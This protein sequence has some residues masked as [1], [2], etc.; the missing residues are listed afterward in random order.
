MARFG[1]GIRPHINQIYERAKDHYDRTMQPAWIAQKYHDFTKS[2]ADSL[3]AAMY[4]LAPQSRR[5]LDVK[6][7]VPDPASP[8]LSE[9]VPVWERPARTVG[10]VIRETGA[11]RALEVQR[12][13]QMLKG[14]MGYWDRVNSE[15]LR[16]WGKNPIGIPPETP[17][18]DA[19]AFYRA[20]QSGKPQATPEM[21]KWADTWRTINKS[22]AEALES[23]GKVNVDNFDENYAP[24]LW[25]H[26][27]SHEAPM[28]GQ[29]VAKAP[30]KSST[31]FLK[32][33]TF[34]TLDEGLAH[35]WTPI[36]DNPIE[37]MLQRHDMIQRYVQGQRIFS[38]MKDN[39]IARMSPT[40]KK[41][42]QDGSKSK[43][44]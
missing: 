44:Q 29:A 34:T 8:H 21:Q 9:Y 12:A 23:T 22:D 30:L 16:K 13:H 33:K 25:K 43:T 37:W 40:P 28:Q 20:I 26:P 6:R 11:R 35:G 10:N 24:Q 32:P 18:N 36:S 7:V 38:Y 14:A 2:T 5:T 41:H 19:Y 17:Y 42:P 15:A 31:A 27:K 4:Y 39:T 3:D 1:E